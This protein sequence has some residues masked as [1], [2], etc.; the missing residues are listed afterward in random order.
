M[1]PAQFGRGRFRT[2]LESKL[3]RYHPHTAYSSGEHTSM[4]IGTVIKRTKVDRGVSLV[5]MTS[6]FGRRT[7]IDS[8]WT[9][10]GYLMN[11]FCLYSSGESLIC[12]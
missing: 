9:E 11:L 8:R 3:V 12:N 5:I 10:F 6:G 7:E 2:S 4:N 1:Q